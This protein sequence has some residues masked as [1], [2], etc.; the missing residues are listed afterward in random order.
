[1]ASV[2]DHTKILS[3]LDFDQKIRRMSYQ[4]LE[5]NYDAKEIVVVGIKNG[6]FQ[7]A[8]RIVDCLEEISKVKLHLFSIELNKNKPGSEPVK[9]DFEDAFL[10]KKTVILVDDVANSGKTLAY[11][12]IPILNCAPH[13][14]QAAVMVD[15]KHKRFPISVDFVGISLATTLKEHI[16]VSFTRGREAAYLED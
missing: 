14:V 1:M 7:L 6:G 9:Y 13:K 16:S 12:L 4:I 11:A 8:K 2:Q 10:T 3:S 15:R 5:Q